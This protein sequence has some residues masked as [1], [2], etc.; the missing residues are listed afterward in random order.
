[1]PPNASGAGQLLPF[2]QHH[3]A[4][5]RP[6]CSTRPANPIQ[7]STASILLT[8][9][10]AF[11]MSPIGIGWFGHLQRLEQRLLEGE[12]TGGGERMTRHRTGGLSPHPSCV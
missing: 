7:N 11:Q 9:S 6:R 3:F 4:G 10:S 2:G 1:M 8:D 5:I 12:G